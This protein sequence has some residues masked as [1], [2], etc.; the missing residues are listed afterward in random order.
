LTGLLRKTGPS[1]HLGGDGAT[2]FEHACR[3]GAEGIVAKRRDRPYQSGRCSDWVKVRNPAAPAATR[4]MEW[5]ISQT[6]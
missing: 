1:E 3:L 5:L 6:E 2:I 4:I